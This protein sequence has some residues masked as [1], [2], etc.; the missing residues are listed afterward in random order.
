MKRFIALFM[1]ILLV[2][3]TVPT[4]FALEVKTSF[5]PLFK[6]DFENGKIGGDLTGWTQGRNGGGITHTYQKDPKNSENKVLCF[7]R[8]TATGS[9]D[10][11]EKGI[12]LSAV[13]ENSQDYQADIIMDFRFLF[14]NDGGKPEFTIRHRY[15]GSARTECY[16]SPEAASVYNRTNQKMIRDENIV[17]SYEWNTLRL[18]LSYDGKLTLWVNDRIVSSGGYSAEGLDA[19]FIPSENG[20]LDVISINLGTS[21]GKMY[22]DDVCLYS[23][24][25]DE[26]SLVAGSIS[27]DDIS[28]GQTKDRIKENLNL[29]DSFAYGGKDYP[30]VWESSDENF[31]KTDGTVVRK[32][33]PRDVTLTAKV[34]NDDKKD[35]YKELKFDITVLENDGASDRTKLEDFAQIYIYEDAFTDE[36]KTA[37]TKNLKSLPS[38]TSGISVTWSSSEQDIISNEGAVTRPPYDDPRVENGKAEV[39]LTAALTL[40]EETI[41]KTIVYYVTAKPNPRDVLDAAMSEVTYETLTDEERTRITK[42][43]YFPAKVGEDV[44]IEWDTS[45][46]GIISADGTVSRGDKNYDVTVTATFEYDGVSDT[47]VYN[48]TVLLSE[49]KMIKADIAA[50]DTTGW[51][52]ITKSFNLPTTGQ[53]YG[54]KFIWESGNPAIV[55]NGGKAVVYRPFYNE[56]D[57][58]FNITLTASNG[59]ANDSKSYSITVLKDISDEETV[60]AAMQEITFDKISNEDKDSVTL[61]LSLPKKLDNGVS[62]VWSSSDENVV[63]PEGEVIRPA[64][65][66]ASVE[67]TLTAKVKKNFIEKTA[68]PITFTVLPYETDNQLIEGAKNSLL[69]SKISNEDVDAVTQNLNLPA[70]WRGCGVSWRSDSSYLT[71]EG[72][73]GSVIRPEWGTSNVPVTL[74]AQLSYGDLTLEKTFYLRI[75]EQ[76]YMEFTKTQ[77]DE[78]FEGWTDDNKDTDGAYWDWSPSM[79][80]IYAGKDPINS[81]NKVFVYDRL[82]N[83]E[84]GTAYV[85]C[86]SRASLNGIVNMGFDVFLNDGAYRDLGFEARSA[87]HTQISLSLTNNGITTYG[88]LLPGAEQYI[89]LND[90][91]RVDVEVNVAKKKFHA[92]LNGEQITQ[93]GKVTLPDGTPYDS[94]DGL[95]YVNYDNES[96]EKTMRM[97]RFNIGKNKVALIDNLKMTQKLVY[98]E[99]QLNLARTW[100]REFLSSNDINAITGDLN[101]PDIWQKGYIISYT[102]SDSS[103]IDQA[104]RFTLSSGEKDIMWTLE[105]TNDSTVYRKTYTLHCTKNNKPVLSDVDAAVADALW[106]LNTL[107]EKYMLSSLDKNMQFPSKGENGSDITITSSDVSIV[108]N[109]GV[110]TRTSIDR[111]VIITITA[112]RGEGTS[113]VTQEVTVAGNKTSGKPASGSSPGGSGSSIKITTGAQTKADTGVDINQ[114]DDKN[115]EKSEFT[116]V[117]KKYWAYNEIKYL[118]DRGIMNGVE[119]NKI[120][121][122][123]PVLREEFIKLLILSK[124]ISIRGAEDTFTD[125]E[126]GSWYAPYVN[127]AKENGLLN[128]YD[129][130]SVGIGDEISREDM[131]VLIFR[132]AKIEGIEPNSKFA[133]DGEISD[134]AQKAIYTLQDSGVINGMGDGTFAPKEKATRAETACM[135]YKAM[136]KGL[137]D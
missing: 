27:F 30:V 33:F 100:E 37:I 103:V 41:S 98:T 123:R 127:T 82:G 19:G 56:S 135:L 32:S 112:T 117:S 109:S 64:K 12:R 66:S 21:V 16:F 6:D 60:D 87:T 131:A 39:S 17:K 3:M 63:T 42:N 134:Y 31:V 59:S 121:P 54:T 65:G 97:F 74:T 13:A 34:Y 119:K 84:S 24:F 58:T 114:P 26:L 14:V 132:A 111:T 137:F 55:I 81:E 106:T 8:T 22:V 52:K 2:I 77:I 113:T 73:Q 99:E 38:G 43:L 104:G 11:N 25:S 94:T 10:Y 62:V 50:I 18:L 4:A 71:I 128:G 108:S 93:N 72:T 47:K 9:S 53:L 95:N 96:S 116:D 85:V 107:K 51:D 49:E 67:I 129:D 46:S 79:A 126:K 1:S 92:Y 115:T 20:G 120:E 110:I 124:G 5:K 86:E 57:V 75:L 89:K 133:D 48:F 102:S 23:D 29:I 45:P 76:E 118:V 83:N 80:S 28:N 90:W 130:G 7:D 69:F 40:N 122:E 125:V 68:S 36:N 44:K 61:N 88:Y 91:N 70:S 136:K 105:I 101:L 78:D 15:D 35:A